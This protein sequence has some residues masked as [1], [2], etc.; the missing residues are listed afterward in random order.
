M[1]AIDKGPEAVA[2][3]LAG[4]DWSRLMS[5]GESRARM[6]FLEA[7]FER[8]RTRIASDLP[9]RFAVIFAWNTLP[10]AVRYRDAYQPS[11]VIHCCAMVAGRSVMRDGSLVVNAFEEANLALPRG[12]DLLQVEERAVRYWQGQ[13]PM[14]LPEVLVQGTVVVEGICGG[15]AE[16]AAP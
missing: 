14:A 15:G 1:Q 3:L 8:V 2:T 9:S 11:G 10:D 4:A 5:F 6:V 12:T 16:G 13:A 7:A